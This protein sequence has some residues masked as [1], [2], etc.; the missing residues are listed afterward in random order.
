MKKIL[1]FLGVFIIGAVIWIGYY[2]LNGMT[3]EGYFTIQE[4][5]MLEENGKYYLFLEGQKIEVS[6]DLFKKIQVNHQYQIKYKWNKLS[7]NDGK[8]VTFN[9]D[10]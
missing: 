10:S 2:Q 7:S 3:T 1:I 5:N 4:N 8:I 9:L 6:E